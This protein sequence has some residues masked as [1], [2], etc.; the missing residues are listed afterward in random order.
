MGESTP[1]YLTDAANFLRM[2][3]V[4][5]S[6]ELDERPKTLAILLRRLASVEIMRGNRCAGL[7][8]FASAFRLDPAGVT[9]AIFQ[10]YR[11]VGNLIVSLIRNP[12]SKPQMSR[13]SDQ[14]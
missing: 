1:R 9:R 13:G 7:S 4:R 6:T 5:F 14:T 3:M 8:A 2:H 12:V 10:N 11:L